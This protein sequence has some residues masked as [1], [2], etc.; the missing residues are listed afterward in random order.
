MHGTKTGN[1]APGAHT[2][3]AATTIPDSLAAWFEDQ[4][5]EISADIF[6]FGQMWLFDRHP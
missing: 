6:V 3:G 5:R 1:A 2:H 4:T